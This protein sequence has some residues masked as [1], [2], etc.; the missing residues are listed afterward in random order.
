[1]LAEAGTVRCA[2]AAR[3]RAA[4]GAIL[5][6]MQRRHFLP[7]LLSV[8]TLLVAAFIAACTGGPMAPAGIPDTGPQAGGPVP[9]GAPGSSGAGTSGAGTA[10]AGSPD[11]GAVFDKSLGDFDGEIGRERE[12]MSKTGQGSGRAAETREAGDSGP[13][14][15]GPRD[16]SPDGGGGMAGGMPGGKPGGMSGGTSGG[17][18]PKGNPTGGKAG[19]GNPKGASKSGEGADTDGT[20]GTNGEVEGEGDKGDQEGA[21]D[22]SD[23]TGTGDAPTGEGLPNPDVDASDVK[24]QAGPGGGVLGRLPA[25]IPA[26][27]MGEDQVA[28]QIREAAMEESDPKVREALWDEYRRLTGIKKK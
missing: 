10:G 11:P 3:P 16:P 27:P 13:V 18:L 5:W 9:G 24:G 28:A 1:M 20:D 21:G 6:V 25:D 2:V 26:A 12:A 19:S 23:T 17:S 7:R 8:A 22:P 14:A 15:G 4:G